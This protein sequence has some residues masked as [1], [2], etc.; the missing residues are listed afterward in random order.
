MRGKGIKSQAKMHLAFLRQQES[1]KRQDEEVNVQEG[2]R[3]DGCKTLETGCEPHEV[4]FLC[5][6]ETLCGLI[7]DLSV[8]G[9]I[10]GHP[11]K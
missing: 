10:M 5:F 2:G 11:R 8:P 6:E 9:E 4:K 1:R 3:E 7:K